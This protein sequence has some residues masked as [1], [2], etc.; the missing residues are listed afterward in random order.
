M[1]RC[2]VLVLSLGV[3][4]WMS[5]AFGGAK[6][7]VACDLMNEKE[8]IALVGGPLGEV[9]KEEELPTIENG[10][11][12]N[13]VCGFFPKGYK[14]QDADRPPERGLLFTLHAMQTDAAAK[15]FYEH[16]LASKRD[17]A[18]IAGSPSSGDRITPLR[19]MGEAAF[20][21]ETKIMGEPDSYYSVATMYFL[22]GSVMG[23][24]QVWKKAGSPM[25]IAEIAVK[26][27]LAKLP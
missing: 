10:H 11:D 14:I 18:K 12:H 17:M 5:S 2:A 27:V 6:S 22:K 15:H 13:S 25:E 24:V 1:K 4:G 26:K 23:Q 9:F 19:G 3:F 7:L 8:A 20:L 21:V 16:V